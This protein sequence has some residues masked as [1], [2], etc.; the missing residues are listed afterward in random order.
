VTPDHP[1]GLAAA[2]RVQAAN[3]DGHQADARDAITMMLYHLSM[4][5]RLM[6]E[7]QRMAEATR[8]SRLLMANTRESLD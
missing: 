7:R 3:A 5:L 2:K 1:E 4:T 8:L 6:P